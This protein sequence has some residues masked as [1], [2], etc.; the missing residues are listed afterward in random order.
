MEKYANSEQDADEL[1]EDMLEE[2]SGGV[3]GII[4]ASLALV[5]V[6]IGERLAFMQELR[7]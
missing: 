4:C 1:S 6:P 7:L 5:L 3:V 2:V